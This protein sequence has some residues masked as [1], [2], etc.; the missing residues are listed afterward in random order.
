MWLC[1]YYLNVSFLYLPYLSVYIGR[2]YLRS[3]LW[4][5]LV[6]GVDLADSRREGS[7]EMRDQDDQ[8]MRER[9]GG[10]YDD[11]ED[12]VSDELRESGKYASKDKSKSSGWK[13]DKEHRSRDREKSKSEIL[14]ETEKESKDLEKER[15][16]SRDRRK[17][18]RDDRGKDKTWDKVREKDNDRDK[19]RDK[20][21]DKDRKDRGKEKEKEREKLLEKDGERGRDK[22]GV[23]DK[24]REKVK[25]RERTKERER[26]RHKN[27]ERERER[28]RERDRENDR[29]MGKEAVEREKGKERTREK[30]KQADQDKERARDR[31][32]SSRKHKDESLD[33]SKDLEKDDS[34]RLET[35]YSHHKRI[36]QEGM[37]Y[38]DEG[39]SKGLKTK[40]SAEA[41]AARSRQP[42]SELEE[43]ILKT[44]EERLKKKLEGGSEVLA[45]VDKSRKLAEKE[46]AL[47]LSKIFEEQDNVNEGESDEEAAPQHFTENLGGV[48]ILH[49]LDK[50]LEGGAVVLTLKDQS[51]LADGDIN[52]EID[53]LENVEMGEQKRRNEAYEA[54]KK[55]TGI[56]DDKFGDELGA[57]KKILPQYDDP[58]ADEGIT[59]DASGHFTGEA[60]KKLEE[61]RKRLQGV[62]ASNHV[63][64]LNST[65]KISTDYYTQEEMLKFKK[66]KKKKSLRKKEKMDL[67]ALEAE[68]ISAGL[69]AEDLGSRND[70]RRQNLREEQE[71]SEAEM[72]SNAYQSAYARADEASKA[73]RQGQ[74]HTVKPEEDDATVFDDDDDELRKSLERAR[75]L[76]L[77]KQ[78]EKEKLSPQVISQLAT[79]S[80]NNSTVDNQN[81]GSGEPQENKVVFTEMEE[82]V[83]GL[84]LDEAQKPESE[85]VFMDEDV[86][87]STSDQ[88]K[89]GEGSWTEVEEIMKNETPAE[90]EEEAIPDETIHESAVGKGLAGALKLLKDRGTLKETVEWGGR[91]MDKKKSKLV[92][93]YDDDKAKEIRIERTDEYGRILTPKE[94]FRLLSHKFHGKG[95]GKM[96]QEKRIRQYQEELKIKQMKNADTPS[97]SVERMREAQAQLMTPYLVLSGH[98]K[99]GQTSDP[100]SGFATVEKDFTGGLT[101][102]L[103]DKKVEHFLNMK[104]KSEP[105]DSGSHKKPK[106]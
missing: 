76:A 89:K 32:R 22:E 4:L 84:Q 64:D 30:E 68:A 90:E 47:Q 82:F 6:M 40:Q 15:V 71:K 78:D 105:E 12:N 49:G 80:A 58:V 31:D 23:K 34:S 97:L 93:I 83:W 100:R 26:E 56:Y 66:P 67:D 65:G 39:N 95:P 92:G 29:D 36:T 79:S 3:S 2:L 103:G 98:V 44:R 81:S 50:V 17:E 7:A 99:P 18:D 1:Y 57:E 27:R 45:W 11:M 9:W 61:L 106:T 94:A 88:E 46:K 24:S 77:K 101:P 48:K 13:E 14:K 59:L 42:A 21:R 10:G 41:E 54:A 55:K 43:R 69:G 63:E 28:E 52:Q 70:G 37:D 25:D 35:N 91:N 85:D 75:K 8:P 51:I 102:M 5:V 73:L 16:S 19:N 38:F 87:P 104:R 96:K 74:T 62:S 60:E 33:R 72:R 20:E 53:M 86:V